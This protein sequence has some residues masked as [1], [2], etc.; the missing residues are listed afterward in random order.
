[1]QNGIPRR[2][3]SESGGGRGLSERLWAKVAQ[4]A[5]RE[6]KFCRPA[7]A[8]FPVI[9]ASEMTRGSISF[10]GPPFSRPVH[11]RWRISAAMLLR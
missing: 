10:I 2:V 3:L 9:R 11:S 6:M 7:E 1:M 8:T 4:E 5:N